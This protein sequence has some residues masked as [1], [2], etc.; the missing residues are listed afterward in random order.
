MKNGKPTYFSVYRSV[1]FG[2]RFLIS[3]NLFFYYNRSIFDKPN[4]PEQ[5]N[6]IDFHNNRAVFIHI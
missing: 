2:F 4:K 3:Q 6:F 5:T 1:F